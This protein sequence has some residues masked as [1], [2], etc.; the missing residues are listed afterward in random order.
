MPIWDIKTPTAKAKPYE[1]EVR[2]D[3]GVLKLVTITDQNTDLERVEID[4]AYA[5]GFWEYAERKA[6]SGDDT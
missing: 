6:P 5:P 2:I 1:G 3:G 4:K